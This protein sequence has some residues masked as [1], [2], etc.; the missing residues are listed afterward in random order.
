MVRAGGEV[1]DAVLDRNIRNAEAIALARQSACLVGIAALKTPLSTYCQRITKKTGVTVNAQTFPFEF[2]Y[3][4]VLPSA[5]RQGLALALCGATLAKAN[6]REIFAT[7]RTDN[8]GTRTILEKS[9]FVKAG[10]PYGSGRGSHKLQLFVRHITRS[11][12][13]PLTTGGASLQPKE[14]QKC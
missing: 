5:R 9:G 3:L 10:T 11:S 2:G 14:F 1:G 4:F 8:L 6:G 7:T 12:E 13:L